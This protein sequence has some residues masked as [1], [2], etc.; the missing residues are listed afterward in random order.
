[1]PADTTSRVVEAVENGAMSEGWCS[2]QQVYALV[3]QRGVDRMEVKRA[4][5][6]AIDEERLERDGDRYRRC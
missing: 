1:V 4:L 6:R 3:T 2:S 5:Q